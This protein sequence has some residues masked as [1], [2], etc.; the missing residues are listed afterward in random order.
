[1]RDLRSFLGQLDDRGLL[2][3]IDRDVDPATEA[4]RLMRELELRGLAGLFTRVRGA[5]ASLA[6][7]LIGSRETL[8]L[9]FGVDQSEVRNRFRAALAHRLDPI[10]VEDAPVQEVVEEGEQADLRRL[11]LVTHSEKDAGAYLTAGA[12]ITS[13]PATGRRNVSINRMMLVGARETGI[14]MMPPQQLGV[15]QARAEAAGRDL[16]VA[17]ALGLHPLDT[18]AAGTSLP[19]GEDEFAL[20]GGL[21]GEPLRLVRGVTV[22][23]DVPADAEIVIEGVIP[24]AVR[25]PEGPFGD[26]LQF[27]VPEMANH[28]LRVTAITHRR[29]PIYQT[30]VA[31]SRED[32]HLLGL[33]REA[34]VVAAIERTGA[35]LVDARVGPTILGCAVAIRQRFPGEAKNVGLAALGAYPWLKYCIVVDHDVDVHDLDDVWWA[36]TARSSP[37]R[38]IR[39]IADAPA[40]PRDE[41]GIHS[42]RAIVDATI[43]FGEWAHYERRTPP[44]GGAL[45]LDAWLA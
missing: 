21:R 32:V 30:M 42:S 1:M 40:F 27:Y 37:E 24:A 41:H 12:V 26:F 14:R 35:D 17:V 45:D 7:N 36:V 28:R 38:A 23:L 34:D 22:A 3:R 33:S 20:A 8:A 25:E 2:A 39:V 16:E 43:P 13:D 44:G 31:G 5:Q 18:L 9:A 19:A 29:D 11:P 6:Y 15:I 10:V 4:A